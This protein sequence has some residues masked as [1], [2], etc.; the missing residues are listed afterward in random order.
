MTLS[1]PDAQTV[2][3]IVDHLARSRSVLFVTGA[4]MSADSGLPTYRGV[5]GIYSDDRPTRHGVRIEEA[6]SGTMMATRPDIT[7]EYFTRAFGEPTN[8]TG[9]FQG[10]LSEHLFWNNSDQVRRFIQRKKGNLLDTMAN[11][12]AALP[13]SSGRTWPLPHFCI[14]TSRRVGLVEWRGAGDALE[15]RRQRDAARTRPTAPSSS[16][17]VGSVPSTS[18]GR[19]PS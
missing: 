14:A 12:T 4:G 19:A 6:L 9:E 17:S 8:G 7:W 5:G 3:R 1:P 10:S 11:S 18:R 13:R 16:K 15:E 2:E